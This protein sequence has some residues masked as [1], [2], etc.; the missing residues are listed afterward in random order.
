MWSVKTVP[1]TRVLGSG[2]SFKM[3][4]GVI[5]RSFAWGRKKRHHEKKLLNIHWLDDTAG[6]K[7]KFRSLAKK[8]WNHLTF[9]CWQLTQKFNNTMWAKQIMLAFGIWLGVW[10]LCTNKDQN[11]IQWYLETGTKEQKRENDGKKREPSPPS[12]QDSYWALRNEVR[13]VF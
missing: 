2:F 10:N 3:V 6:E 1:K 11:Q 7:T 9:K 5:I 4:A 13:S 8:K 12:P